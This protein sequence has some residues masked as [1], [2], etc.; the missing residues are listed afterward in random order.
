[1]LEPYYDSYVAMHPDGRR[2][3]PT[4]HAAR[5]RLPP[6][7]RRAAGGGR[8]RG[9]GSCCSTPRT[10]RPAR[11][12]PRAEL[13]ARRRAR[14]RARPGRDHRRGLRAPDLRRRAEHV[15]IATLP[16]MFERTL[17]L[18]SAG[19]SYS[20]TGWKVGWATGP[21]ELVG[22]GAGREA[23]ADLHLGRAAPAGGGAGAR[24]ASRT[25]RR[26]SPATSRTRRDL[27]C[28]GL[29]AGRP[30]RAYVPEGTYFATTDVADLGWTTAWRSASPCPSG[31][32]WS[33]SRRR[34][35]TTTADRRR[36]APGALGVLQDPRGDPRRRSP[37]WPR[38]DLQ[39]R[40]DRRRRRGRGLAA[41]R[42][43]VRERD[44]RQRRPR[45][46]STTRARRASAPGCAGQPRRPAW[47]GPATATADQHRD[48]RGQRRRP[49]PDRCD[50]PDATDVDRASGVAA[51]CRHAVDARRAR[52]T[53]RRA[54]RD[55]SGGCWP[56]STPSGSATLAPSRGQRARPRSARQVRRARTEAGRADGAA[57]RSAYDAGC[58]GGAASAQ[59]AAVAQP[60]RGRRRP[61][62][63]C[64]GRQRRHGRAAC[65]VE[66]VAS[67][68][69]PQ[70]HDR[71]GDHAGITAADAGRSMPV[72][73]SGTASTVSAEPGAASSAAAP[74]S[75]GSPLAAA[76]PRRP[77]Q[78][79]AAG[80][81]RPAR[82]RPSSSPGGSAR[83]SSTASRVSSERSPAH[84]ARRPAE[85]HEHRAAPRPAT[86]PG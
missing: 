15:P 71:S 21:A 41:Q 80:R 59:A 39:R 29:R 81:G 30:R 37:G 73:N 51:R 83:N 11:C 57:G 18:S 5:P 46:S 84:L 63:R 28:D 74:A 55:R 24:R 56:G 78:R 52:S 26:R 79:P 68:L 3:T 23:V 27:L 35:S 10:T 44:R 4:G 66:P 69:E 22:R 12:S 14:G 16:G 13:Q 75:R 1:M 32:A 65:A 62:R 58:S 40:L 67:R 42:T 2:R 47:L 6:R 76:Q 43:G 82:S 36:P 60:A 85:H 19:K 70:H 54:A 34:S 9:P 8:R 77:W 38:A 72:T 86:R 33:R 25:S 50:A 61:D 64:S 53:A 7:R 48:D 17:T 49:A 31:P 20:F 45:S